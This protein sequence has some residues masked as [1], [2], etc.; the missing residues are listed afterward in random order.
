MQLKTY[1]RDKLNILASEH[2][3]GMSFNVL[4]SCA[5][6]Y[7]HQYKLNNLL[8]MLCLHTQHKNFQSRSGILGISG[9]NDRTC[10]SGH[11]T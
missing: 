9:A 11:M 7:Q 6:A 5:F 10:I 1:I 3:I 4:W 2:D 8:C